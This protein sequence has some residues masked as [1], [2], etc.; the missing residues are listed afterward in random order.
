MT[1]KM[2]QNDTANQPTRHAPML[3]IA[4]TGGIASGKSFVC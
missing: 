4:I 1:A 2:K 3:T